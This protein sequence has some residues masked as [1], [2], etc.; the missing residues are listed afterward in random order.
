MDSK[1]TKEFLE[2]IV[3]DSFSML[4]VMR[5]LNKPVLAGNNPKLLKVKA[6]IVNYNISME[7]FLPRGNLKDHRP[8]RKLTDEILFSKNLR[9]E[10]YVNSGTYNATIIKRLVSLGKEYRC[11]VCGVS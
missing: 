9:K 1:Y 8:R 5:K 10:G 6:D 7:H 11:D 3:K 2:S 4:E